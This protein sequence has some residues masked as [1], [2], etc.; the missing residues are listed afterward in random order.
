MK[1]KKLIIISLFIA[2]SFI[3]ANIKI[4]GSIAFDS[5]PGF[6]CTLVLGPLYGA[7]V[8]AIGHLL[9]AAISGFPLTLPVHII[10]MLGMAVTMVLFGT[11]Y[12]FFS[13]ISRSLGLVTAAIIGVAINGP[14][15]VV[16]LI[17]ILG[18]S[19]LAMIPLLSL[20]ALINIIISLVVYKFLPRSIK[21]WK[22]EK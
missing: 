8:G 7:L 12:R 14:I 2:L 3:G 6:L 18:K 4:A 9:T 17:P 22:S 5:M 20:A 16:M 15:S 13:K 19:I 1:T 11:T 10:I 21:Q